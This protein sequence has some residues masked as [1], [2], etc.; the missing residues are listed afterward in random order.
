MQLKDVPSDGNCFFHAVADPL[1]SLGHDKDTAAIGA[2][3]VPGHMSPE[4]HAQFISENMM[5]S[6]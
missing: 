6:V 3:F 1:A 4:Q 2:E 5:D